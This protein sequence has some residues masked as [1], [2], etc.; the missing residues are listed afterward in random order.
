MENKLISKGQCIAAS[1]LCFGTLSSFA[2]MGFVAPPV[3]M[4]TPKVYSYV[5]IL[6]DSC[7]FNVR[8]ANASIFSVSSPFPVRIDSVNSSFPISGRVRIRISKRN[9]I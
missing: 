4:Q 3:E 5:S 1:V 7:V 9:K 8:Y 2:T 6:D